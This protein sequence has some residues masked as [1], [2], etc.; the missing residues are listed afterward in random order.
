METTRG[1]NAK[2]STDGA[3]IPTGAAVAEL[4]PPA[5]A[6]LVDGRDDRVLLVVAAT[7]EEVDGVIAAPRLKR[8]SML[9]A[10][11]TILACIYTGEQRFTHSHS[12]VMLMNHD[13]CNHVRIGTDQ[14]LCCCH[15]SQT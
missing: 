12:A 2:Y 10:S 14:H 5:A 4:R 1:P 7:A 3:A 15:H 11:C 13:T 8:W 6:M 9:N